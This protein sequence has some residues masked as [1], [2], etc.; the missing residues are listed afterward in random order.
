MARRE[1]GGAAVV[2][3]M[4][5][6]LQT[7]WR[8]WRVAL[9]R[10][11]WLAAA[12][13]TWGSALGAAWAAPSYTGAIPRSAAPTT[14]SRPNANNMCA[15]GATTSRSFN[16]FSFFANSGSTTS[17]TNYTITATRPSAS[18]TFTLDIYQ[19]PFQPSNV[20]SNWWGN[21]ASSTGSSVSLTFPCNYYCTL[22]SGASPIVAVVSGAAANVSVAITGG[23][24]VTPKCNGGTFN[25]DTLS[26]PA[27]GGTYT[28]IY[29]P[30]DEIGCG[31]AAW[32]IAGIP[33]W[34]T[35]MPASGT[36]TSTFS[37]SVAPN[38]D[39][40]PR[41]IDLM[42]GDTYF[43][44]DQDAAASCSYSLGA[45]SASAAAAGGAS[46]VAVSAGPGCAWTATSNAAW[47]TGVTASGTGPGSASYTVAANS[48]P[49]RTGT[50]TI[51]GNAFTVNQASGCAYTL[52]A[53]SASPGAAGGAGS[54][55][56]STSTGCTWSA[57]SGAAW[58][59]GVT[60]TL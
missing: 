32:S 21:S 44:L 46:S 42:I 7:P 24:G 22:A 31:S 50:V 13:L 54:I 14:W 20:C 10:V 12:L 17:V 29:T 52:G 57:T 25:M 34:I 59:T 58:I 36:G 18:G 3:F 60:A 16:T 23:T 40:S 6:C 2:P 9:L 19:A 35:G 11:A 26:V 1:C 39:S 51:A 27:A 4:K 30:S 53:S 15:G 33:S 47:I 8:V 45:S 28:G 48:G 38:P 43:Q 56:L 49:A 41:Y 5:T 55:V 37:F